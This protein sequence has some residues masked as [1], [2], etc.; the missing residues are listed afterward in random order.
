MIISS[1]WEWYITLST[2]ARLMPV[3]EGATIPLVC[4]TERPSLPRALALGATHDLSAP[5]R[6]AAAVL[7]SSRALFWRTTGSPTITG[8]RVDVLAGGLRPPARTLRLPRTTRPR[9]ALLGAQ[10]RD[11]HGAGQPAPHK[12]KRGGQVDRKIPGSTVYHEAS[13]GRSRRAGAPRVKME[14]GNALYALT[15][16]RP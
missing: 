3:G 12:E 10:R 9:F 2:L 14:E 11:L 7:R 5:L 8:R 16:A 13:Q 4:A 1:L 6:D 15:S